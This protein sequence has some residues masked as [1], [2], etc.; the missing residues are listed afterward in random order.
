MAYIISHSELLYYG[1]LLDIQTSRYIR[2]FE[3]D[4]AD[5]ESFDS[6]SAFLIAI[7]IYSLYK[8]IRGRCV[9]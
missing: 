9:H 2:T 1:T 4:K 5:E 3:Y 6:P 7:V 8:S